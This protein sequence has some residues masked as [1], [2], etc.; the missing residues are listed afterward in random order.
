VRPDPKNDVLA[1]PQGASKTR[2]L[3]RAHVVQA[4]V[5]VDGPA[6]NERQPR[7][8]VLITQNHGSIPAALDTLPVDGRKSQLHGRRLAERFA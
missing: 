8:P 1:L 7:W 6:N 3:G 5:N 2:M 4:A